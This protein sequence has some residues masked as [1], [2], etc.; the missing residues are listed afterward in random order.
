MNLFHDKRGKT[1]ATFDDHVNGSVV[2]PIESSEMKKRIQF[3]YFKSNGKALAQSA[4]TEV[5][6]TLNAQASFEGTV[7]EI[8][9]RIGA[10][11]DEAYIDRGTNED[12]FIRLA[13]GEWSVVDKAPIKF[14]RSA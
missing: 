1:Y 12:S 10:F 6:D 3:A 4:L 11:E 14:R 9:L 13:D 5:T 2:V 7:E 8:C